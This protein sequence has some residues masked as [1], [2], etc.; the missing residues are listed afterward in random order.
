MKPPWS[1]VR[2]FGF[3]CGCNLS[4]APKHVAAPVAR[5][6]R[7]GAEQSVQEGPLVGCRDLRRG[8]RRTLIGHCE[9]R[10]I[11]SA[12]AWGLGFSHGHA[13]AGQLECWWSYGA[14]GRRRAAR[15]HRSP[16]SHKRCSRILRPPCSSYH[17]QRFCDSGRCTT[18]LDKPRSCWL[19][20]HCCT[21][22][23]PPWADRSPARTPPP[24]RRSDA[25]V[26]PHAAAPGWRRDRHPAA[27]SDD[28]DGTD[29]HGQSN[30]YF[31]IM[32]FHG[33]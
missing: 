19:A 13:H 21:V 18:C 11:K 5:Q 8:R 28:S 20:A 7:S 26:G 25:A 16:M 31:Q 2:F 32:V 22:D 12:A 17:V 27:A 3:I 4:G 10:G 6:H 9:Q 29:R 23:T 14:G 15:C 24:Q 33:Q 30:C 1:A